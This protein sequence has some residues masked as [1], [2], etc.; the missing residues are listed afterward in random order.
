[1]FAL[2]YLMFV[3]IVALPLAMTVLRPHRG[4]LPSEEVFWLVRSSGSKSRLATLTLAG[5]HFTSAI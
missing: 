5:M 3:L 4:K 2:S 1:M